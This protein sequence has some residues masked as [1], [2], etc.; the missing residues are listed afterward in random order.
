M[1]IAPG[2]LT[3]VASTMSIM[4]YE[5]AASTVDCVDARSSAA[6]LA[7][8]ARVISPVVRRSL[9]TLISGGAVAKSTPLNALAWVR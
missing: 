9:R 6:I 2:V 1:P 7:T 5:L 4:A 3:A 8:C